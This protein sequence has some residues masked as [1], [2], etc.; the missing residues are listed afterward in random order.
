MIQTNI[1]ASGQ[2]EK[3]IQEL[4]FIVA[5]QKSQGQYIFDYVEKNV[6]VTNSF[7]TLV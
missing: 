2:L 4:F 5:I 7:I 1:T 6:E 3:R